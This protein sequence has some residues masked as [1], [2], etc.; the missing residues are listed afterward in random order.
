MTPIELFPEN[1][2]LVTYSCALTTAPVAIGTLPNLC[3]FIDGANSGTFDSASGDYSFVFT[4]ILKYPPGVYTF[5][6]TASVGTGPTETTQ[7]TFDM[8]LVDQCEP[9]TLVT[10]S[11]ALADIEYI[12]GDPLFTSPNFDAFTSDPSFCSLGYTYNIS[13]AAA[14]IDSVIQLDDVQRLFTIVTADMAYA[15]QQF[16]VTVSALSP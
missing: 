15:G 4:D 6:V 5:T 1:E 10:P 8:T 11:V 3:N 7:V 2:C 14:G 12:V 9:P 16:T 13:P